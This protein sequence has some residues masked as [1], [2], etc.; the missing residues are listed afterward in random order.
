MVKQ[1]RH[2]VPCTQ[3]NVY[4]PV[5]HAKMIETYAFN[6]N[7]TKSAVAEMAVKEFFVNKELK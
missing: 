6:H 4:I 7:I 2:R 3:F 5:E 1:T